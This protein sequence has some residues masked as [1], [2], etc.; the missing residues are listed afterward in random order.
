MQNTV[1]KTVNDKLH[2]GITSVKSN[3]HADMYGMM[4][5]LTDKEIEEEKPPSVS[6]FLFLLFESQ[7]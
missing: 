4:R 6:A 2:V 5:P 1:L 7:T 3:S